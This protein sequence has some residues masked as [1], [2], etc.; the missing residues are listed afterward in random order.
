MRTDMKHGLNFDFK[1]KELS[2]EKLPDVMSSIEDV[3]DIFRKYC[4]VWSEI[5]SQVLLKRRKLDH[6]FNGLADTWGPPDVGLCRK[7]WPSPYK[8]WLCGFYIKNIS[9]ECLCTPEADA[10][11]ARIWVEP[12]K[13]MKIDMGSVK[14]VF[15]PKAEKLLGCKTWDAA[16]G[17]N[18]KLC[19]T[20]DLPETRKQ[21]I[22]LLIKNKE[23][24]FIDL[25]A[26]H[27]KKLAKLTP[28]IDEV[29]KVK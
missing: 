18:Q 7:C 21:L 13:K 14:K 25:M 5:C 19:L 17:S 6:I 27:F 22:G 15:I 9:L 29:Y 4:A 26:A 3:S 2:F 10:P 28:L 20:F 12:P 24:E 23:D 8:T 1:S 11:Y 16:K